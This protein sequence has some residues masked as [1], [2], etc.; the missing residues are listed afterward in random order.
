MEKLEIDFLKSK[1]VHT[2]EKE[3][4]YAPLLKETNKEIEELKK[5]P[6][7]YIHKQ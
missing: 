2:I 1:V 3:K 6:D 4:I 7:Y 5:Y